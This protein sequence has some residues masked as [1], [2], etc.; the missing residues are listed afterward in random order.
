M[1]DIEIRSAI[2]SDIPLLIAL[3]HHFT[4]DHAW[5]M[6]FRQE[7]KQ[8]HIAFR[9]IR[10]PR[11]VQVAYPLDPRILADS[12][13]ARD[14]LLVA[15]IEDEPVGYISLDQDNHHQAT[16]VTDVVVARR[17]RRQKIGSTL[18]I[19]AQE[20]A[21]YHESRRIILEL[22]PKNFPAIQM[23]RKLGFELCGYHDYYFSNHDIAI[24][25]SKWLR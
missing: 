20:W 12:W 1:P 11:S 4:S 3:E 23:A 17:L 16:R 21:V 5:Q 6:N 14:G 25:F 13:G 2:A 19:A 18:V 24:F 22:Q 10:L 15:A 9:E 7:D 8:V